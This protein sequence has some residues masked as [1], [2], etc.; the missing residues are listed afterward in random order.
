MTTAPAFTES[1]TILL[2]EDDL[3]LVELLRRGLREN[4]C[5][6]VAAT[7]GEEGVALALEHTFDAVILDIGLPDLSGYEVARQIRAQQNR[8]AILMLTAYDME[9]DIIR[10]LDLGAD[11]YM[12]KPFSFAELLAR[13]KVL[14]RIPR[15]QDP[16]VHTVGTILV[17]TRRHLVFDGQRP[18]RLTRTE[19]LLIVTLIQA[20][21]RVISRQSLMQT[22]WGSTPVVSTGALDT[23]VNA[24]RSKLDHPEAIRTI[25]GIGYTLTAAPGQS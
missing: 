6:V 17:D 9:D 19:F 24:L 21:E 14:T 5:T 8:A 11:D 7:D 4:G 13:L 3:R 16:D 18:V 15:N 12:T 25:R 20:K 22:L 1:R 10:G 23:L 2:I